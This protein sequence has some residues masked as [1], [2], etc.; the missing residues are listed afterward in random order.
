MNIFTHL[1]RYKSTIL[2]LFIAT[3]LYFTS[4]IYLLGDFPIFTDEAIYVRWAQIA[5]N[6]AVWRFISLTDGKQ[7]MFV[8]IAMI[9]MRFFDDP[10]VAG[11]MVSVLSGFFS[12]AGLFF[13]GK[14]LFNNT[15]VGVLSSFLY[16]I[17]P[18]ALVYDRMALYD[19]LVG[20]FTVWSLYFSILLVKNVRLDIA[21]ILGMIIGGGVLTKTNAFF[22]LLLLPFNI[23]I[24]DL[25]QKNAFKKVRQFA[26]LCVVVVVLTFGY[27][28]LLRLSPFFHIIEE[29]NSL[30][31]YPLN[32]WLSHPFAYLHSNLFGLWDWFWKYMT[33][34]WVVLIGVAFVVKKQHFR[35]KALLVLYFVIPF[36]YLSFFGRTIYPRFIFFM[37]LP[38]LPLVAY[39]LFY[40][41]ERV[42]SK[43]LAGLVILFLLI[44]PLYSNYF[45]MHDFANAPIP[46]PDKHQ[47][48]T[49]WPSGVGVKKAIEFFEKEA[50]KGKIYIGT[51]GTFGLMP[52]SLEIY[53]LENPNIMLKGFWPIE[54]TLPK[55]LEDARKKYPTYFLTYQPCHGCEYSGMGP[56]TW[57][58][59]LVFKEEKVDGAFLSVYRVK[60]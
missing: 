22:S 23:L 20:A 1:S 21:L 37:T 36:L 60:P 59:E 29:K 18:F 17:Y 10:L 48:Y 28:S 19:S 9:L 4:R 43:A 32:E 42:R 35:E 13:V 51:E 54:A 30:F 8:W 6:D 2:Y 38:L 15:K 5:K 56:R 31:V 11:R 57:P 16:A 12:M 14:T 27:Y 33:I 46:L 24:F 41:K 44:L 34:P 58:L 25:F 40:I 3:G 50:E 26:T 49:D 52:F 53:L 45:I 7:P 55:E 47:Y 39:S